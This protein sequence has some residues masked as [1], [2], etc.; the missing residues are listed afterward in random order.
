MKT[1]FAA[2]L[3]VAIAGSM[4]ITA[5]A[6]AAKKCPEGKILDE[7]TGKCVTPRGS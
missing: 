2:V 6:G 5:P 3:A 1:I 4:A 7:A